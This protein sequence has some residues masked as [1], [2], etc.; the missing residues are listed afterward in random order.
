M[1]TKM[2]LTWRVAAA[3]LWMVEAGELG[4]TENAG[5]NGA[6]EGQQNKRSFRS[7]LQ[8][9]NGRQYGCRIHT[10]IGNLTQ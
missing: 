10:E 4:R 6:S 3:R 2:V 5:E 1:A 8:R 9:M 7:N